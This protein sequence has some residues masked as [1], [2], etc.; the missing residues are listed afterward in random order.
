MVRIDS[1][2]FRSALERVLEFSRALLPQGGELEVEVGLRE[3]DGQRYVELQV[4]SSSATSLQVEEKDVFRPFLRVN[5]FQVGLGIALAH[6]ILRRHHGKI[7]FQKEN[8]HRG[9]FTILL[10]VLSG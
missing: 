9:L 8:P 7:F 4:A 1:K 5:N 3:I 6:Q 2:Q 10:R